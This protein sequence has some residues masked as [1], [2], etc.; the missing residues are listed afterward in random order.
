MSGLSVLGGDPFEEQNIGPVTELCKRVRA[1][2]PDK[3]IWVWTGRRYEHFK[4]REIMKYIDTLVDGPFVEKLKVKEQ[5]KY[6]GSTNQR[7]IPI[8][9]EA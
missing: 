3:T 4:D 1:A 7:V 5:G 2:C 8:H 9:P 6:F